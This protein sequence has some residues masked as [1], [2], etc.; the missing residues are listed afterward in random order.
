MTAAA[1]AAG[2]AGE[3]RVRVLLVDD[4]PLVRRALRVILSSADDLTVVGEAADGAAAVTAV[5]AHRPEVVLM[6]I[7]MPGV[8]GIAATG[9]IC[10]LPDPPRVI[11]LTTFH[12]DEYVFGALRA[13]ASGFLLKDSPPA[14]IAQAVRLVAAGDAMLSPAITRSLIDH[15]AADTAAARAAAAADRLRVLTGREKEVAAEVGRGRSNAE[16]ARLLYMSEATVK[17]HISRTHQTE[18]DQQ[19]PGGDR[20]ARCRPDLSG[21][22]ARRYP[23]RTVEAAAGPAAGPAAAA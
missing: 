23:G 17:A 10:A 5:G 22:I 7:R 19:G 6:D 12:L 8:D 2:P 3:R 14:D 18:R 11:V 9:R 1:R 20:D 21:T 4:D 16:I 15:Y 13:G